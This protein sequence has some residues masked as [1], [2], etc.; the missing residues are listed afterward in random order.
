MAPRYQA[1]IKN[2]VGT[3]VGFIDDW[4]DL[5]FSKQVNGIGTYR[6]RLDGRDSRIDLFTTDFLL[7]VYRRDQAQ[8]LDWYLEFEALGRKGHWIVDNSGQRFYET[9][10]M[11]FMSLLARRTIDWHEGEPEAEK[12]GIGET[13]MKEYADENIGPGATTGAGRLRGGVMSGV[14]IEADLAR[15]GAWYGDRAFYNLLAVLQ[16]ISRVTDMQFD[17][18]GTGVSGGI[19]TFE[20]RTYETLRGDDRSTTGLDPSTGL[21]GAGNAPVIF[22]LERG[23]MANLDYVEDRMSEVTSVLALGSG[24]GAA[25]NTYESSNAAAEAESPWNSIQDVRNISQEDTNN[26]MADAGEAMLDARQFVRAFDFD[27]LQ[28]DSTIYGRDYFL[29]DL[30]TAQWEGTDYN[31]Q[32]I[33][34]NIN[35]N[36]R[37]GEV[38]DVQFSNVW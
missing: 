18:I 16:E 9:E 28:V 19:Y 8:S 10:G 21:N 15:G 20:F 22:S 17:M 11:T 26:A 7:E 23:N 12:A 34:V 27:V 5:F 24:A 4:Q 29:G 38:I 6:M 1:I 31:L 3:Q 13:V 32:I 2:T 14:S 37:Q 33:G 25:R 30:I 36:D 35:V